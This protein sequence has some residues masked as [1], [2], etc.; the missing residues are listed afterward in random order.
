MKRWWTWNGE[1]LAHP[2]TIARRLV[3]WPLMIAA[4]AVL[5]VTVAIGWGLDAAHDSW[6]AT[7]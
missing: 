7:G 2:L 3:A 1:R 4:R 5:C 6:D